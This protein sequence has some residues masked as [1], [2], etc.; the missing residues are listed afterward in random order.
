MN[1][2]PPLHKEEIDRRPTTSSTFI[3][4]QWHLEQVD[5]PFPQ[6]STVFIVSIAAEMIV[7]G[8]IVS[9]ASSCFLPLII[10]AF[11]CA[12][13]LQTIV[14]TLCSQRHHSPEDGCR[15][16]S[17]RSPRTP[18]RPTGDSLGADMYLYSFILSFLAYSSAASAIELILALNKE[19]DVPF[20]FR[21]H[22]S[23]H[24]F[25]NRRDATPAHTAIRGSQ[26]N[27]FG[28]F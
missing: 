14:D 23:T 22:C 20:R 18:S 4:V 16:R 12:S 28:R 1:D 26:S 21:V 2:L 5:D 24:Y 8:W 9:Y 7:Y 27:Y 19:K 17:P 3:H 6:T 25:P 13:H 15:W 10:F 11:G